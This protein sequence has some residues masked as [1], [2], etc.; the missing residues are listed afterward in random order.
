MLRNKYWKVPGAKN[1]R[2]ADLER[3][4]VK[5]YIISIDT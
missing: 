3:N 2:A 5:N 4:T 1:V